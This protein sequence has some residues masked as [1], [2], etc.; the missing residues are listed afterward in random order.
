[1]QLNLDCPFKN[2][3]GRAGECNVAEAA[4]DHLETHLEVRHRPAQ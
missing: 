2:K 3:F 1:M 4:V